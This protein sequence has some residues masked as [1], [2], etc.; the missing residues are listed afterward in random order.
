VLISVVGNIKEGMYVRCSIDYEHPD[1]PRRFALGQVDSINANEEVLVELYSLNK[2][3]DYFSLYNVPKQAKYH[4]TQ[5]E[6]VKI[7]PDTEVEITNKN[8]IAKIIQFSHKDSKG[9]YWYFVEVNENKEKNVK[10]LCETIL[11]VP[12]N[13]ADVNPIIQL[14][15]YELN[16]PKW[17]LKREIVTNSLHT[18]KNATFGFDTLVGSRVFLLKHQVDTIVRAISERPCRFM[19][20]DEVGLGKTIEAIII[21]KGLQKRLGD[22]RILIITPESLLYQWRNELS[23]KFWT[24][25]QVYG[26]KFFSLEDPFTLFP[27]EKINTTIGDNILS[28]NWDLI[29]VDETHRLLFLE[30]EYKKL[31][32]VSQRVENLLLLS[33]TPIQ[34]RH[35]EFLKLVRLLEPKKYLTMSEE[36]FDELLEKQAY[37]RRRVYQLMQDLPDYQNDELAED[38]IDDF[39]KISRRLDDQ[40][41]DQ[42]VDRIDPDSEDQ[43]LDHVKLVLAYLAENYQI[44]RKIIRHRRKELEQQLPKRMKQIVSYQMQGSD[45]LYHEADVNDALLRYLDYINDQGLDLRL[46]GAFH[47]LFLSG[48]YSSPFALESIV[49]IRLEFIKNKKSTVEQESLK[50]LI[51]LSVSSEEESY[52]LDV[53]TLNKRW[54]KAAELEFSNMQEL[55]DD[56]DL[57]KG[58]LMFVLDYISEN[59]E[60]EK[61]VI[62]SQWKE[63]IVQFEKLLVKRFGEASVRSFYH[64]KNEEEL[65][66]AVDDFQSNPACR[67]MVCDPLGGEGRN[68]Q[69]ADFLIHIDLPWSPTDL[70]QRIG[71]IDRLNREKD[72]LSVVFC[73]EE[74][75]EEELYRLWDD[76]L[77]VFDESLSGIEIALYEIQ[78]AI[79]DAL[80]SNLQNGLSNKLEEI[81]L[82]LVKMREKVEEERFFD[83][84][85]QLDQSVEQQLLSLIEQFDN[86]DGGVLATT[87][88]TWSHLCGLHGESVEQGTAI[89]YSPKS[90]NFKSMNNAQYFVPNMEE[91]R[92]RAIRSQQLRGTFIRRKAIERED[93]MFFA[94]GDLLFDSIVNNAYELYAGRSTA[95]EI[96]TSSVD[97]EGFVFTWSIS[98]NPKPL[99]EMGESLD[100]LYHAQGYLPLQHFKT[101]ERIGGDQISDRTILGVLSDN[102]PDR[103]IRHMGKRGNGAYNKFLDDYPRDIWEN[104]IE[105]SFESS[106]SKVGDFFKSEVQLEKAREDFQQRINSMKASNLYYGYTDDANV[107]Y[108]STIFN[109]VLMGID[110]PVYRLESVAFIRMVNAGG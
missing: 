7:L 27:L 97:W 64:G 75:I 108:L 34:S 18:L 38:F 20:A 41:F 46:T 57:I 1:T 70:E 109:A 10:V 31:L 87:M 95:I 78:N 23:F 52:L 83:V 3:Y 105:S 29:I 25:F 19:L 62:F 94:P 73:S 76:G 72:V 85:R 92:K 89:M 58:R 47:R 5:L 32:Q 69:M 90:F 101:V 9:Y 104:M 79:T 59:T 106:I 67:F 40:I 68:F 88:M 74:T 86:N 13:R 107:K 51:K 66:Q 80:T 4:I 17:Y 71:R 61:V 28:G 91:A 6:H 22:M 30:D 48:M 2:L 84:A 14:S 60:N 110:D 96:R 26:E 49:S 98:L 53:M 8:T 55:Y 100:H 93:L 99:I 33:A 44:E 82:S 45:M 36:R 11:I 54:M 56:P 81:N 15:N 63:T 42:L 77:H 16:N 37:I 65:Q 35:N 103:V 12:F 102:L 21:M 24:D 39:E 43:G 50:P